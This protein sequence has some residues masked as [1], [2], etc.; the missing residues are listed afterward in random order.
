MERMLAVAVVAATAAA[1]ASCSPCVSSGKPA[2]PA[3]PKLT[4]SDGGMGNACETTA[5]CTAGLECKDGFTVTDSYSELATFKLCTRDCSASVCPA[6]FACGPSRELTSDGG[7]TQVCL[8]SCTSDADC[9]SGQRAGLCNGTDGGA[10][11]DGG[12]GLCRPI[13]CG[14]VNSANS[15]PAGFLCQDDD[16][17]GRGNNCNYPANNAAIAA[18]QAAWCGK[19]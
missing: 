4:L 13:V 18:P 19:Q 8:P 5:Q 16:Y 3:P 15:C 12:T 10:V 6:G 2:D 9:R 17:G 14:G 1:L 11:E 7:Y